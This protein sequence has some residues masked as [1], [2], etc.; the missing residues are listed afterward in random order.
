MPSTELI[1]IEK[2]ALDSFDKLKPY[3]MMETHRID[4]FR[5]WPFG[6]DSPCSVKKMA[7]AGFYWCGNAVDKDTVA[8]FVCDKTLH[9]WE[10]TD[11][12]WKEHAKHAPQCTLVKYRRCEGD[13]T[14][15]PNFLETEAL[16]LASRDIFLLQ[17]DEFLTI[18][19]I[20]LKNSVAKRST[21]IIGDF[22]KKATMDLQK[23]KASDK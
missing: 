4:T 12:P 7:E 2:M 6:K 10:P 14:V 18:F 21:Q 3:M 17:V 1:D 5:N 11:D 22:S 9:G 16:T 15:S 23:Y 19:G 20:V 13:L 8:C